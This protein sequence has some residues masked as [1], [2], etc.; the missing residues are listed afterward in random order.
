M[1][2]WRWFATRYEELESSTPHDVEGNYFFGTKEPPV[3]ADAVLRERFSHVVPQPV[4]DESIAGLQAKAGN[5]WAEAVPDKLS[6]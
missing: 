6:S 2:I 3:L 1:A 4:L 5:L